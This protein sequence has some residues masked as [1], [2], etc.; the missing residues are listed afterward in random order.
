MVNSRNIDDLTPEA[1]TKCLEFIEACKGEGIA[2]QI[3]QTLR[4]AEYQNSL[5]QQGRNGDKRKIVT[6]CDGYKLKSR[7]QSGLAWD[8]VPLD[9]KGKI[10]WSN[11]NTFCKMAE[12]AKKLGIQAGFYF[13]MIDSPHFEIS[14]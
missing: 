12:I 3:I 8:A 2:V 6:K 13:K 7:H 4:D 10:V 14:A 5:Y 1:K 11:T 9:E